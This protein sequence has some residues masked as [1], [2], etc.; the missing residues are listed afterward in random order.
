[1]SKIARDQKQKCG[2]EKNQREAMGV[3]KVE[4]IFTNQPTV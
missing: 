4:I 2:A 1:M 3:P